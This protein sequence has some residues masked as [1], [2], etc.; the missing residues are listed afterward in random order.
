MIG[1]V[2]QVEKTSSAAVKSTP[3]MLCGVV[4]TGGSD[5]ASVI[6]YDNTAGSGTILL[7]LKAA[8][9]TSIIWTPAQPVSAGTG[10]Y[11]ALTGTS[12][13]VDVSYV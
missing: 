8:A 4:L 9:N 1:P 3:G 10:I 6:I 13:A 12:P 11:A 5:A 7:T 2:T